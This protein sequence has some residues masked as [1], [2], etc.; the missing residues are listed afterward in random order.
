MLIVIIHSLL[1]F[2]SDA[3]NTLYEL[4]KE[5][6]LIRC[7]VE[8]EFSLIPPKIP[9]VTTLFCKQIESMNDKALKLNMKIS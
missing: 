5:N 1:P 8:N 6:P 4:K 2:D 3:H 7:M 9:I